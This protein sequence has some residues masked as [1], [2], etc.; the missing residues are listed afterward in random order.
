MMLWRLA[1]WKGLGL[2]MPIEEIFSVPIGSYGGVVTGSIG[3]IGISID[4]CPS[5][6][7]DVE[8]RRLWTDKL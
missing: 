5:R 4:L 2:L 1:A 3:S 8:G 7:D 6:A